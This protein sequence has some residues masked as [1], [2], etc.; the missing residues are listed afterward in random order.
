MANEGTGPLGFAR[1]DSGSRASVARGIVARM[2]ETDT[3]GHGVK[4]ETA[5]R[6]GA[7]LSAARRVRP[8]APLTVFS[9]PG[10]GQLWTGCV[11]LS[12]GNWAE[13]LS[14]GWLV[15]TET[16]SILAAASTM[17]VRSGAGILVAPFAGAIADKVPRNRLLLA[18]SVFKACVVAGAGYLAVGGIGSQWNILPLMALL[19]AAQAFEIPS[20][21]AMVADIAGRERTMSALAVQSVGTRAIGV[22]GALMGGVVS[23]RLGAPPAL[24]VG[25]AFLVIGGMT[26]YSVR[27]PVRIV[28]ARTDGVLRGAVDGLKAVSRDRTV[29]VLLGMA[30]F[31]EI[32]GFAYQAVLPSVAQDVL[33]LKATGYGTLTVAAGIG[34]VVGVAGMSMLGDYPR[35]GRL[36]IGIIFVFGVTMLAFGTSTV[37]A[38]SL[39]LIAVIGACMA[40]FDAMQWTMLQAHVPDAMRGRVVAAWIFAIG[41][42]WTGH[43][44][45]GYVAEEIGV[46]WA[47]YASGGMLL[48]AG[49]VALVLF[50]RVRLL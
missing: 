26:L 23:D 50:R 18:T 3:T 46:Q 42:G 4:A 31:V 40:I 45:L 41:F 25:A 27:A 49:T 19:G 37:L 47:L 39:A 6:Q 1:G 43:L 32:F 2:S 34:A 33:G 9:I 10:Y 15:L 11:F 5:A 12:L 21:Q 7:A 13:R 14:V 48:V 28:A 36:V 16:G 29:A 38:I 22:F 30:M 17:A 20:T 35:K 44:L 24:Y 8:V